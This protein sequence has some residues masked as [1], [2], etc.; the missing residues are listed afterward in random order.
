[1]CVLG[2]AHHL[3]WRERFGELTEKGRCSRT[4]MEKAHTF[5]VYEN[6]VYML[7]EEN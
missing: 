4:V 1:M 7:L 2:G 5:Y 6:L 3:G